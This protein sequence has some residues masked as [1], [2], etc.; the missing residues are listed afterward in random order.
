MFRQA[1]TMLVAFAVTLFTLNPSIDAQSGWPTVS[2][3][4]PPQYPGLSQ[5]NTDQP[6]DGSPNYPDAGTEPQSNPQQDTAADQQHA[7]AR[8]SIVQGDVNIKR[9]GNGQF[10]AAVVNAPIS[11]QDQLQTSGGSRAEVE[12]DASNLVRLAP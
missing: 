10:T 4:Q 3:S 6:P 9:G 5:N 2:Q 1:I 8:L 12:L 7:I 11:A